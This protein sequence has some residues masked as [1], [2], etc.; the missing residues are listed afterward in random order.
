MTEGEINN[1]KFIIETLSGSLFWVGNRKAGIIPD[2]PYDM[3]ELRVALRNAE[4]LTGDN[5]SD[6]VASLGAIIEMTDAPTEDWNLAELEREL[7]KALHLV[8]R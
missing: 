8:K 5:A 2:R 3:A 1:R 6:I 7:K 4:A